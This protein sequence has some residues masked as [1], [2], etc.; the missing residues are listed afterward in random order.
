MWNTQVSG[1]SWTYSPIKYWPNETIDDS[2]SAIAPA[3]ADK[4]SFF[5]YAPY[6]APAAATGLF[7]PAETVGIKALTSNVATT[8]PKVT[9]ATSTDPS[10]S[11]DLLWAVAGSAYSYTD[12]HGATVNVAAGMPFLNLTKPDH[13]EV[14]PLHFRHATTRLGFKI[15]GAFDQVAAGGTLDA[16]TKVT[17][18]QVRV[19]DLNMY[20]TGLLNLNNT[21]ANTPLWESMSGG[22]IT[23]VVAG[24]DLNT[25]IKDS[26]SDEVQTASVTNSAV[27]VF[28]ND[29]TYFNLIPTDVSKTVR[30]E[31][32]YYVTTA[33]GN[34]D[35][36]FS[37]VKN[38]IY[39]DITFAS[40][41]QA[42]KSNTI[43]I[44]LGLTSVKLE[45]TVEDWDDLED[46]PVDLPINS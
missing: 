14:I 18:E 34:L 38:V 39:K 19:V 46:T 35:A 32:T 11:V 12:V 27:N 21:V 36:G 23:L 15:V 44:I 2:H 22:P 16:A 8:D 26:G 1:A 20:T 4:L 13:S 37:R 6:V 5:A 42:G 24:D 17:V 7:T 9:F 10:E 28:A 45:A 25:A 31:I 40:G 43:K 33:D 41:L 3:A 30:V 29:K